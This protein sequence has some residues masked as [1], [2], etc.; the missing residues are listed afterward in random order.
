M[1]IRMLE[2]EKQERMGSFG[3]ADVQVVAWIGWFAPKCVCVSSGARDSAASNKS[4]LVGNQMVATYGDSPPPSD[5]DSD[6]VS[7]SLSL[8]L[9]LSTLGRLD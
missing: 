1:V 4:L 6:A 2:Q 5:L 7:L 9:A 8:S 3:L